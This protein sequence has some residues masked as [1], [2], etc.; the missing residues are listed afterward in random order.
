MEEE[1]TS[2]EDNLSSIC[3]IKAKEWLAQE[4]RAVRNPT[5]SN[6]N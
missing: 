5:T 1:W 6:D 4:K 2:P 3:A